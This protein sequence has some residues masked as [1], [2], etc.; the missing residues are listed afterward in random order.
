MRPE[1]SAWFQDRTS[2]GHE[3]D[4]NRLVRAKQGTTVSVVLPARDE[5]TTV[6]SIVQRLRREL[7]HRVPLID[8]LIVVDSGS[9]DDTAEVARAAGARVVRQSDI[10]PE[11][12]DRPGKGEALWKSLYV[13][14][15]DI[16]AFIDADLR[17]FDEQF[18]VGLL[19][20]LLTEPRVE[21]VKGFYDRPLDDGATLLPAGGG[22]VTELLARPMLNLYYPSLA[23]FVQPLAGEYAARRQL[24]ERLPF[25]SGYGVEIA[26]LVDVFEIGGLQAM[27]QVDLGQRRH[28]NSDDAALGR[29]AAQVYLAFASRLERYGK[30]IFAEAPGELLTQFVRDGAS[31]VPQVRDVGVGD[32]PPIAAVGDYHRR[33]AGDHL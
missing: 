3:W 8:E 5:A 15:G 4:R 18:A 23:G 21:F 14:H 16:V 9:T 27:A 29:M 31:F 25:A 32:R 20:P 10:L 13:T 6:G 2:T 26:M 12:G 24:L 33:F 19:G 22:R 11:L 30:V 28:R 7:M 1:V 17:D